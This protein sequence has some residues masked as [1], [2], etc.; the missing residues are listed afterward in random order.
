VSGAEEGKLG[1][2]GSDRFSVKVVLEVDGS[3]EALNPVA[4]WEGSLE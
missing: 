2:G 3:M 4:G 1:Q